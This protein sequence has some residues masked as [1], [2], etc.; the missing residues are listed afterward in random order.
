MR[1]S[2]LSLIRN[3]IVVIIIN[4]FLSQNIKLLVSQYLILCVHVFSVLLDRLYLFTECI[5][6]LFGIDHDIVLL[7]GRDQCELLCKAEN[8]GFFDMLADKVMD[9]T[10]CDDTNVCIQGKCVVSS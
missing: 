10:P 2:V 8:Y 3:P 7:K 6:V 9:G 4:G 1:Y 5:F